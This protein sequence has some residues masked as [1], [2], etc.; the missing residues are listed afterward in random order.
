MGVDFGPT[1]S[2]V[3]AVDRGNC[4]IVA[5]TDTH[6]DMVDHFPSVVA[7]TDSGLVHGFEAVVAAEQGAPALRSMKRHLHRSPSPMASTAIGL[8]IAADPE[9]GYQLTRLWVSRL[10]RMVV[11][12]PMSPGWIL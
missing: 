12:S 5:F 11:V 4:P 9:A 10:M 2:V 7:V 1:H 6:G 8:A 3:S